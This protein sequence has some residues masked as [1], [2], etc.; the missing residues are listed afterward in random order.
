MRNP[1]N[2]SKFF[3][4]ILFF[5]CLLNM[6]YGYYILVRYLA[7]FGFAFL[8]LKA[9]QDEMQT[10]MLIYIALAILFQPLFKITLG[11]QIWNIV[12]VIVGLGLIISTFFPIKDNAKK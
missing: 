11:R 7:L 10:E 5:I 8:A 1:V 6:P 12:D 9:F 2:I 4:A 3:L